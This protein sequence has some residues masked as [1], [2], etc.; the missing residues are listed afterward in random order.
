MTA[1]SR[2]T[3]M[4]AI[5]G[6]APKS[7][8]ELVV[9]EEPTADDHPLDVRGAFPDEEHRRLPVEPLDLVLLGETVAAVDSERVLDHLGAV[10]RGQ[11]LRH[12]RLEVVALPGVL[13]AG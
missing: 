5:S 1:S 4:T 13:L 6:S 10:L 12:A 2:T 7:A 8:P 11:V 3:V 9:L